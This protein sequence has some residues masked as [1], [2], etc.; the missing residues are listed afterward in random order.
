MKKILFICIA[1]LFA[2]SCNKGSQENGNEQNPP[3]SE[4]SGTAP[5]MAPTTAMAVVNI[6]TE[7]NALIVSKEDYIKADI[8]ITTADGV[9]TEVMK[10]NIRGRGN[11]S[12]FNAEKKSY[13]LKFEEKQ[14]LL[15]RGKDKSWS[16][17]ANYFDKT[18]L[19]NELAFHMSRLSRFAYT[20]ATDYVEVYLNGSYEGVY[21]LC[22]HLKT[23]SHRMDADYLMEIDVRAEEEDIKVQLR[24]LVQPVVVKDPEDI[25]YDSEEYAYISNFLLTAENTLYSYSYNSPET[26]YNKYFD[27]DSFIDWYLINEIAKNND[28]ILYTSCYMNHNVDGKLCMGPVWDFDIGFGNVNYNDNDKPQG[29]WIAGASWYKRLFT[30]YA[31]QEKVKERFMFYYNMQDH[32]YKFIDDYAEYLK[33]YIDKNEER[34]HTMNQLLWANN[35][36]FETYQ[37]YIDSLK[38]WLRTRLEWMKEYYEVY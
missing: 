14:S 33:P 5:T 27:L 29:L 38:S 16:L 30:D 21:V 25:T 17:I 24:R 31:F 4:D 28:A 37:E 13:R 7:N 11:S 32:L 10:C 8:T 23:G 35:E 20:P 22:D 2:I 26:G 34:W 15:G 36:V 3:A 9:T 12:W 1:I 18:L 19:R 6:V